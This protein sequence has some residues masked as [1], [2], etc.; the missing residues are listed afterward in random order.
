MKRIGFFAELHEGSGTAPVSA[1]VGRSVVPVPSVVQVLFPG[2]GMALAYYNDAFDLHCGDYVYV[3]GKLEGQRG[4]VTEVS[5][6]FRIRVS[7]YKRVIGLVYS[8]VYGEFFMAGSHFVTV[9]PSTLPY[10][11]VITWFKAP[12]KEDVEYASGHDG[13]SFS[14]SDL[15]GMGA[16]P[17][18]GERGLDYYREN[19]VVYCS[20]DGTRG[21]AIVE[22]TRP[23]ELEFEYS[24]GEVRDLICDCFCSYVCKHEV[25]AMIQLRETLETIEKNYAARYAVGGYFAAVRKSAL[26]AFA[27]DGRETGSI[28]L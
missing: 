19:K 15:G 10:E 4:R 27:V 23:Y 20:M 2:R 1:S 3:D 24:D 26:F 8:E 17:Q 21:R 12:E 14:L 22:G 11:K 16:G 25:A 13:S 18:I 28:T 5:R 9:D 7:D 6:R